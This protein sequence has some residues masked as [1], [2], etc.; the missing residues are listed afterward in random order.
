M[1]ARILWTGLLGTASAAA[2]LAGSSPAAFAAT[3]GQGD[4]SAGAVREVV[5]TAP[6]KETEARQL[7]FAAPNLINIQPAETILKY[8]DFNAAE[9]LGR[10]PGVSIS[11]DTGEGRFVNIRGIDGNL[12]GATFGGVPLLNTFPGGTYFGGGGRAVEYDTIPTGSIDGIVVTKT[13]LPDH[14]AE[15]LGGTVEL[16]PR[17]AAN[18]MAPFLDAAAGWGYEPMHGHAGPLNLDLAFGARFGLDGGL[19]MPGQAGAPRMGF[20]SNPTPFAFVLTANWRSDRRGFD[21][22]E[23]D[24]NDPT[25]DRAYQDYQMRRYDYHR[26]RFGYG[27][28][29]DFKPNDDHAWYLRANIAG[30]TESVKKNRVTYD[31]LGDTPNPSDPTGFATTTDIT[32][33]S[34]DEQETHRNQVYVIGG[35]DDFSGVLLDY[36]ASYS[37]ATYDQ[38]KNYGTKFTGPQGLAFA[39]N[40]TANNG[41]FPALMADF[42][43]VNDPTQYSAIKKISDST[44]FDKDAE[45]AY[46]ANLQLPLHI[47]S[48]D[49]FLKVGGQARLRDKSSTPDAFSSKIS[50]LPLAGASG[51]A[52]TDFY[53]M[54]TNGPNVDLA[55][56]RSAYAAGVITGGP[57]LTSIFTAHE[58]IYAGY[59]EYQAV[60]CRKPGRPMP[61][62]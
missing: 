5:V 48:S 34:T 39:Y 53:G 16:T 38:S 14:E 2:V 50:P 21:D 46:A 56:V 4:Q 13:P 32:L 17:T 24:P 51:P 6:R 35:R 41:D 27:G 11:S 26:R 18:I 20:F 37:R 44:E 10:I 12:A 15:S 25:V 8:P 45:Y 36:R 62:E 58:D 43:V 29:F 9:A 22:I 40:N 30:Y 31:D 19:V 54:Y 59:G 55:A 7:Q 47:F 42:N 23:A 28:E 33:A 3:N 60:F 1:T 61:V 49:D 57:D 52:I